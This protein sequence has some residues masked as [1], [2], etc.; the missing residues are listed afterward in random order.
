MEFWFR[1]SALVLI[2]ELISG[3][4]DNAIEV[5]QKSTPDL[6]RIRLQASAA[7]YYSTLE[8]PREAKVIYQQTNLIEKFKNRKVK[9]IKVVQ[10]DSYRSASECKSG[11]VIFLL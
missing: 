8:S 9:E 1:P 6:T 4:C 3:M 11:K 5:P 7:V 10:S 2:H